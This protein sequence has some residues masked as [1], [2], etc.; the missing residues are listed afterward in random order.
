MPDITLYFALASRAF[1]PRWLLEELGVPYSVE[2]LNLREGTQKRPDYLRVNAMGKV[3]ALTDGEVTISE[4]P[5]ICIYLA[6]RYGYGSLA[7][8]IEAPLRGAY[9][10]WM[11]FSTAVFEPAVYLQEPKDP[12]KAAGRGWG[13]FDTVVR[14]LTE[15]LAKGPWLL[16]DQFSAADVM[17]GSLL[18]IAL[19]NKRLPEA[20]AL[21]AYDARL[22]EREAYKRAADATWPPDLFP[23]A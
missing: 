15:A 14:V 21:T 16:G 8:K 11:V 17:L 7:P 2:M 23:P 5:A 22:T 13:D 4:N 20:P 12:V 6:D 1:T 18:S 9:L 3:P 10:R 19:I